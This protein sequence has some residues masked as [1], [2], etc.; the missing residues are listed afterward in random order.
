MPT[1]IFNGTAV[2]FANSISAKILAI[3]LF[4]MIVLMT[5]FGA[6]SFILEM[7][8]IYAEL[9]AETEALGNRLSF[10]LKDPLYYLNTEW[11]EKLVEY[12]LGERTVVSIVVKDD[13]ESVVAAKLKTMTGEIADWSDE[14]A[15]AQKKYFYKTEKRTVTR[16]DEYTG[17]SASIGSV[18]ITTSTFYAAESLSFSLV[19]IAVQLILLAIVLTLAIFFGLK[20]IVI[21]RIRR[22]CS[23]VQSLSTGDITVQSGVSGKDEIGDLA[24]SLDGFVANVHDIVSGIKSIYKDNRKM[25]DAF[26][27]SSTDH[28]ETVRGVARFIEDIN[29]K[30]DALNAKIKDSLVYVTDIRAKIEELNSTVRKQASVIETSSG[31]VGE[32]IDSI[33]SLSDTTKTSKERIATL[34]SEAEKGQAGLEVA[35]ASMN[36]V[37]ESTS[38]IAEMIVMI[39]EVA[40]KTDVLA[41]NASIEAAHAGLAGK[42]FEVI[43]GEIRNLAEQTKEN[44][45]HISDSLTALRT[46]MDETEKSTEDTYG[47]ISSFLNVIFDLSESFSAF[48][49]TLESITRG[50]RSVTDSLGS[51]DRAALDIN[52]ALTSITG[53]LSEIGRRMDDIDSLS[54]VTRKSV[55]EISRGIE[56]MSNSMSA[57]TILGSKNTEIVSS[58]DK[59]LV[60]FK[61]ETG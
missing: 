57:L 19:K 10:T 44:A 27:S 49:G 50:N 39:N 28:S 30:S 9:D 11:I 61:T 51:L 5:S 46:K 48:I 7:N 12:E 22:I 29:A 56:N 23:F 3:L 25:S 4:L 52:G 18:E 41:M 1:S 33:T 59:E 16:D 54:S 17:E 42:G 24:A 37:R 21:S 45:K 58:L 53:S 47:T 15:A 14:A 2:R 8:G 6:V 55:E 40:E 34:S 60:R 38:L 13:T 20:K 32:I 36:V 31:N 43:A 35:I 26:V